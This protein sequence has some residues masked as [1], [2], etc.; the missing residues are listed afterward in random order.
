MIGKAIALLIIIITITIAGC[1]SNEE[2]INSNNT[3]SLQLKSREFSNGGNLPVQ[4]TAQGKNISP[5]L[6][7]TS[8]PT[9]TKCFAITLKDPD[10]P[11]GVFYHWI[12]FNIP[13]STTK[14]SDAVPNTGILENGEKQGVN[15]FGTVGYSGPNP[16]SGTHRYTFTLYALNNLLNLPAG[17][18]KEVFLKAIKPIILSQNSLITT[19]SSHP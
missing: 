15:D 6:S 4:Y 2:N 5:P 12:I 7:W 1:T 9:G 13:P 19:Y 17:V 10:S 16:P 8:I 11:N 3:G 14:L 18:S